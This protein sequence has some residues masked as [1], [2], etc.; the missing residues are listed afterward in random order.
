MEAITKIALTSK[1]YLKKALLSS[2]VK[3]YTNLLL[4]LVPILQKKM[5]SSKWEDIKCAITCHATIL[6]SISKSFSSKILSLNQPLQALH[7]ATLHT[8]L[9]AVAM[10]DGKKL[11][12][13][14]DL[15]WNGQ[16]FNISYPMIYASQAHDF[17]EY[18]PAYL[19]HSHGTKVYCWFTPNAVTEA[20]TM[21][22]DDQKNQPISP[23]GLDLHKTLQL[24]NL[25][26]CVALLSSAA[27]IST[28]AVDLDNI[29]LPSFNTITQHP[30]A[31]PGMPLTALPAVQLVTMS[32]LVTTHD[33][34]TV[35][36]TMDTHLS[37]LE[38]SS[39]LLPQMLKW[40]NTLAPVTPSSSGPGS[41]ST[42]S[43]LPSTPSVTPSAVDGRD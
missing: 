30:V 24:L 6:Q 25:D 33:D 31:Q 18:L 5:A 23:D 40:L 21:G 2:A 14:V 12:L 3:A 1:A 41:T 28:M 16:G 26:W 20:Q 42:Q 11:F 9:M 4:L 27:A 37:A 36:S 13:L 38:C 32:A 39:A 22:W 29:T 19:A 34:L 7:N 15:T 10:T 35:A 43:V 8:M 17:V